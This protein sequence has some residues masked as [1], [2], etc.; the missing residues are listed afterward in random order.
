MYYTHTDD[1]MVKESMKEL[2][3]RLNEFKDSSKDI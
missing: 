2:D 1:K 3:K